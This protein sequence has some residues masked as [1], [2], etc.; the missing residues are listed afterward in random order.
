MLERLS[1]MGATEEDLKDPEKVKEFA[2]KVEAENKAN[3]EKETTTD[4]DKILND[5]LGRLRKALSKGEKPAEKPAETPTN[6]TLSELDVDNRV[7]T[8]TEKL[9]AKQIEVLKEYSQLARNEGKS[10]EDIYS[11]SAV[12]AEMKE[13]QA[14][15]DAVNELDANADDEKILETKNEI[16]GKYQKTGETP[17]TE[18]EHKVIVEKELEAAGFREY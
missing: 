16:H 1:A 9:N 12:Q 7:F 5:Q 2:E 14:A 3:A 13:I 18:Y 4:D 17:E 8:K 11:T 10:F 15:E 6:E